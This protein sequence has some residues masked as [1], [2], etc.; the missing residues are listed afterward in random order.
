M[1]AEH[2]NPPPFKIESI[3]PELD[4]ALKTVRRYAALM[5]KA[6]GLT[7]GEVFV[8]L[9]NADH[10]VPLNWN[11]KGYYTYYN[12]TFAG[13]VKLILD[14]MFEKKTNK[15]I[16]KKDWGI[17]PNTLSMLINQGWL[18]L[19]ERMDT[20]DH[21]YATMRAAIVVSKQRGGLLLEWKNKIIDQI[22][23]ASTGEDIPLKTEVTFGLK[24]EL[25]DWLEKGADETVFARDKLGLS[26]DAMEYIRELCR[27][28]PNVIVDVLKPH[29]IK[30]IKSTYITTK[31]KQP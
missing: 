16:D 5:A 7:E 11:G 4:V 1:D 3:P 2:P 19:R 25:I 30:I 29:R 23:F 28:I 20:E 8:S 31:Q 13:K 17:S 9:I 15:F 6:K 10:T 27:D 12:A 22:N 21:K 24:A 18:Y 14:E 26:D